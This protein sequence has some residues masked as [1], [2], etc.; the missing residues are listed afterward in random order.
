MFTIFMSNETVTIPKVVI[1][2]PSILCDLN[3]QPSKINTA[4]KRM[5][6]R[7]LRPFPVCTCCSPCGV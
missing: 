5:R 3:Q 7:D 6:M 1:L 4:A 2:E